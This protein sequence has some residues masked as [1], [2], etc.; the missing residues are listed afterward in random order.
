MAP[1]LARLFADLGPTFIKLGQLLA[2]REDLFPPEV[3][4]ALAG[5]HSGVPPM[6]PRAVLRQLERAL[7]NEF[8]RAFTWIDPQPLAAASIGQVHRAVLRTGEKV[9]LK[10]QRPALARMVAADLALMR[11]FAGLLAQAIPELAAMEPVALLEAF[12]RSITGELD[13]TREAENAARL[14]A[15][16]HGAP[17]VRLPR[18]FTSLTRPTLLVMEEVHGR[19]LTALAEPEQKAARAALLRA[20][21][22]Q[23]LDHGV[24]HADPHPGNVLVEGTGRL[25]LID[26]GAVERV[27]DHLRAGLG[28]LVRALALGRK[29][30]LADAV[31]ALS[32]NGAAVSVDRARLEAEL[33]QLVADAGGQAD[34][35]RV[36]AQMVALGRTPSAAAASVAAHAHP[37]AGAARRRLARA[38]SGARSRGRLAARVAVVVRSSRDALVA[39]HA[40]LV[41]FA[42]AAV[43]GDRSLAA[44]VTTWRGRRL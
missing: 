6:K 14:S 15:L 17:E 25:V 8:D 2:T 39:A 21:S 35:A 41:R 16:L 33:G 43:A 22:R 11:F 12:E 26:L 20:F 3:T 7:G 19:R 27:D 18:I 10:I 13:F 40:R 28:R 30:A 5:L 29:R 31:L 37:R 1:R 34:G 32:P 44:A 9:V 42:G 24:F 23:I 36:L 4:R 38:R